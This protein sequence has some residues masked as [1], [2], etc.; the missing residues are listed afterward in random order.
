MEY[1]SKITN[2]DYVNKIYCLILFCIDLSESDKKN[3]I[4]K[5]KQNLKYSNLGNSLESNLSLL[6]AK[7]S[8]LRPMFKK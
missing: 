2:Q 4:A 7:P 3:I 6:M 5:I 8:K 1:C